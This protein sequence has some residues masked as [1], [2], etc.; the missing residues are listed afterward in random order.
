[1]VCLPLLEKPQKEK[2]VMVCF[3]PSLFPHLLL[4]QGAILALLLGHVQGG[5]RDL[6]MGAMLSM[7]NT[8]IQLWYLGSGRCQILTLSWIILVGFLRD[9]LPGPQ[10]SPPS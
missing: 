4:N 10:H 6:Q 2:K 3:F 7:D 5:T 9:P 8:E 1:L